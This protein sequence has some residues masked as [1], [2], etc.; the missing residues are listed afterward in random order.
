MADTTTVTFRLD[1]RLKDD[2]ERVLDDM[3]MNMTTALTIFV[4]TMV[5]QARIPFTV[6]SDPFYSET[7]QARLRASIAKAERGEGLVVK[8]MAELDEMARA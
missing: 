7:N 2:A 4:K 1:R 8:T 6:E 3:G 5:R